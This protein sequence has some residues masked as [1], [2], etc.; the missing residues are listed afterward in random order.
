MSVFYFKIILTGNELRIT[1]HEVNGFLN[2]FQH[3]K[4][5]KNWKTYWPNAFLP[6][7]RFCRHKAFG[8][9][10]KATIMHHLTP[11]QVNID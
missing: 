8:R 10:T 11:K 3:T 2:S 1:N 6:T 5:T 4:N 9:I 7:T